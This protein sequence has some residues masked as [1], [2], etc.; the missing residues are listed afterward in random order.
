MRTR[1]L[2]SIA[3]LGLLLWASSIQANDVDADTREEAQSDG[4]TGDAEEGEVEDEEPKKERTTEI[5]EDK[6][7][8]VLHTNNFARA[9][10]E[11]Q[12]LLV[13]FCKWPTSIYPIYNPEQ[14]TLRE[15]SLKA[16]K[17]S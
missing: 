7:V 12:Y 5:E 4:L 10:E 15:A 14:Q 2:L 16:Q 1:T 17:L 13:E 8:M 11:N 6:D 3:L 9:L